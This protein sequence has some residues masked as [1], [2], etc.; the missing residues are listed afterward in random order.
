MATRVDLSEILDPEKV[1][2]FQPYV[3]FSKDA[4]A[5]NVYFKPDADYS[6]RLTD[7]VTLFLSLDDDNDI[8]GC[9]I[10]GVSDILEDLPNYLHVNHGTVELSI[11]FLSFRGG[12]HQKHVRQ[13][14]NELAKK[15]LDSSIKVPLHGPRMYIP[16][17]PPRK[18]TPRPRC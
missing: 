16:A 6:K 7:H 12:V 18:P 4:D 2:P 9:R 1:H 10:K 13:A 8:V 17:L 5:L 11:L 14:F 15:S 3:E